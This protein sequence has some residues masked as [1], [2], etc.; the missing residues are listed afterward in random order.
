MSKESPPLTKNPPGTFA[1]ADVAI[2]VPLRNTEGN[3]FNCRDYHSNSC[4]IFQGLSAF[5]SNN[6]DECTVTSPIETPHAQHQDDAVMIHAFSS[7][8]DL[9]FLPL[10]PS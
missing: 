6:S 7:L 3:P 5:L 1:Q 9:A 2:D 8:V 10:P 4:D